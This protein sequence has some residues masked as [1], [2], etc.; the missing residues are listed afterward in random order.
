M[1]IRTWAARELESQI[2]KLTDDGRIAFGD[3]KKN[4]KA[5]HLTVDDM[6]DPALQK[7]EVFQKA[8]VPDEWRRKAIHDTIASVG[9]S[10]ISNSSAGTSCAISLD[11]NPPP[12]PSAGDHTFAPGPSLI[13]TNSASICR[14]VITSEQRLKYSLR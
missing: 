12:Q 1:T 3:N 4:S 13:V 14:S 11:T 8:G 2:S 10:K 9:Q 7:F 5:A 6:V